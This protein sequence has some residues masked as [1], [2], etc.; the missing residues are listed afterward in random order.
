MKQMLISNLNNIPLYLLSHN[1]EN[2]YYRKGPNSCSR[3]WSV[4]YC[5]TKKESACKEKP[6]GAVLSIDEKKKTTA[7]SKMEASSAKDENLRIE[8]EEEE[9]EKKEEEEGE[10]EEEVKGRSQRRLLRP[11]Q[12]FCKKMI[13]I[14]KTGKSKEILVSCEISLEVPKKGR[15][16]FESC[17]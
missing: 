9:K 7:E 8:R 15:T 10:E 13:H 12:E 5:E 3:T 16:S 11:K 4:S 1:Y 6:S 2:K 14:W 17:T